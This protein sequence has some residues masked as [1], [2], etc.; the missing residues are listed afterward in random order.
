MTFGRFSDT[1][2][3]TMILDDE[4]HFYS[5]RFYCPILTT[6]LNVS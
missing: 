1:G 6:S 4:N 5:R 3:M 2:Q